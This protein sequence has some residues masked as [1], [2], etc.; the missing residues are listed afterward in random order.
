[1]YQGADRGLG[2]AAGADGFFVGSLPAPNAAFTGVQGGLADG[3][4]F[5]DVVAAKLAIASTSSKDFCIYKEEAS[6]SASPSPVPTLS[7]TTAQPSGVPT[8]APSTL[9]PTNAL[10]DV[11]LE[12]ALL[13]FTNLTPAEF[14]ANP[15]AQ[16][17]VREAFATSSGLELAAIRILRAGP[18]TTSGRSLLQATGELEVDFSILLQLTGTTGA[19]VTAAVDAAVAAVKVKVSGAITDGSYETALLAALAIEG[20]ANFFLNIDAVESAVNVANA[21][22]SFAINSPA[23]TAAPSPKPTAKPTAAPTVFT[24]PAPT[25]SP[26]VAPTAAVA[27]ASSSKKSSSD[28]GTTTII[29]IVVV[30]SGGV[31]LIGAAVAFFLAKGGGPAA[32]A[33]VSAETTY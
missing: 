14:L 11:E 4:T 21:K 25:A 3:F 6:P 10:T 7:P 8:P 29:I 12:V 16:K 32:A 17:A 24:S 18:K 22:S 13:F 33:K 1:M 9:Q 15:T 2:F 5:A 27:A 20:L 28:D 23:P 30:V 31:L 19:D 26:T